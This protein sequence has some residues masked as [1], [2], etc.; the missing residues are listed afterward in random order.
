MEEYE[1]KKQENL[2]KIEQFQTKSKKEVEK[3]MEVGGIRDKV[4]IGMLGILWFG[5]VI[6]TNYTDA[7]KRKGEEVVIKEI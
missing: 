4:L 2:K 5:M 7:F 1:V 3:N 6:Y